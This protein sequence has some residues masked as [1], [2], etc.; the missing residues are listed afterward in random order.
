MERGGLRSGVDEHHADDVNVDVCV[1]VSAYG[2]SDIAHD[3]EESREGE[4]S[5][6][7][8]ASIMSC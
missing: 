1:V 4:D 7:F 2:S 3:E 6:Y 8:P 5:G